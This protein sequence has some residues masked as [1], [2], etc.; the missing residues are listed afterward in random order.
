[1]PAAS[2]ALRPSRYNFSFSNEKNVTL[3]NTLS[4]ATYT[5]Q[6]SNAYDLAMS[7]TAESPAE[8]D[9]FELPS[10]V[11]TR[12]CEGGFLTAL[13]H[14]EELGVVRSRFQNARV[15][16]PMVI[17]IT[18]TMN[19]N[20]ACYYCYEK[21]S[22][23]ALKNADS[24]AIMEWVETRLSRSAKKSLHIDWFGGEPLLN[25][26][27]L[28]VVSA[29]LQAMCDLRGVIFSA[30]IISNGTLWPED[31]GAFVKRNKIRQVQISLDGLKT[32]HDKRRRYRK[33]YRPSPDTSSFD[34]AVSAIDTLLYHT[35]VDVRINLDP[36][37]AQDGLALVQYAKE[38]GWFERPYPCKLYPARL[39]KYSERSVF[40]DKLSIEVETFEALARAIDT[41]IADVTSTSGP[42]RPNPVLPRTGVCAAL[43]PDSVVVGPD[44][45]LYRCGLQVSEPR[46]RVGAL[47]PQKRSLDTA[48]HAV[49]LAPPSDA[50]WWELYDP[51][52]DARCQKCSFLPVCWGGCPKNHLERDHAALEQQC[53]HW[54]R[55]L[56]PRVI[57]SLGGTVTGKSLEIVE[58]G[59]NGQFR[60]QHN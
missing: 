21:R 10:N 6:G 56:G 22:G 3:F 60:T 49:T 59:D 39:M 47:T 32:E 7:L 30:S 16:A 27:F 54:R 18:T 8:F 23:H 44:R 15:D 24:R 45:S 40:M 53:D 26:G 48:D 17:T 34:L 36:D 12:L 9:Y 19:C 33:N 43:A 57:Q 58:A 31:I 50:R 28:E 46:R 5:I 37:N 41:S 4:G 42:P 52:E 2:G 25:A 20:L 14:A 55:N 11:L 38:R 35:Q 13:N 1:M 51:T 29:D